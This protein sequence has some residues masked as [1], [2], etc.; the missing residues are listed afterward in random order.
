MTRRKATDKQWTTVDVPDQQGRTIVITGA[1]SGVGF[2][3]AKV[4]AQRGAA[5]VLACRDLDKADRA[6]ARI[7]AAAPRANVTTLRLDLASLASVR[8]AASELR[9][10]HP[11][12]DLLINNAG[13]MRPPYTRTEDGFE[14]QFGTNHLGHFAFTGLVLDRLLAVPGSRIVT[15]SSPGH[16][17]GRIDFDE[18]QSIQR[19]RPMAAYAQSKLANLLFTYGPAAAAHRGQGTDRRA[20]RPPRRLE[21]RAQPPH[22]SRDPGARLLVGDLAAD[23]TKRADRRPVDPAI[24]RRP[25]RSRRRLLRSPGTVRVQGL[26]DPPAVQRPL[27]RRRPAAPPVGAIRAADRRRLSPRAAGIAPR[28]LTAAQIPRADPQIL[29]SVSWLRLPAAASGTATW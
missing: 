17:R 4:L 29:W 9:S 7:Q 12:L 11:R 13:V 22:A 27:P 19:Y 8:E 14:L 15:V 18:L 6:A 2:E 5:V 23:H 10:S 28:H 1:N 20:G 21:D 26:P 24:R 16:R 3:T 25:G